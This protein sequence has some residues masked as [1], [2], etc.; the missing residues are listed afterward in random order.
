MFV[1][2]Q[3]ESFTISCHKTYFKISVRNSRA[4]GG[5]V[6]GGDGGVREN[7][8]RTTRDFFLPIQIIGSDFA[9]TVSI[10]RSVTRLKV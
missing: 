6:W 8:F 4:S 5:V 10:V 3:Y 7:V 1:S 2:D 9:H